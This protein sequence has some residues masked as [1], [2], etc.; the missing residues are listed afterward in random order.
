MTGD[1]DPTKSMIKDSQVFTDEY[2]P[3]YIRY[4]DKEIQIIRDKFSGTLQKR[5]PDHIVVAGAVGTGK[6][7]V[8]GWVLADVKDKCHKKGIALDYY[9]LNCTEANTTYKIFVDF[10]KGKG[11]VKGLRRDRGLARE[12]FK[13]EI[14]KSWH[15]VLV[16]DEFDRFMLKRRKDANAFLYMCSRTLRNLSLYLI[17]GDLTMLYLNRELDTS[18]ADTFRFTPILFQPYTMDDLR[19]ILIDRMHLGLDEAAWTP[20]IVGEIVRAS[21]DLGEGVRGALR[22]CRRAIERADEGGSSE[23]TQGHIRSVSDGIY[24]HD[25]ARSILDLSPPV[26]GILFWMLKVKQGQDVTEKPLD[27]IAQW[28]EAATKDEGF[29]AT[30]MS[31]H[32]Y[33][34]S[35]VMMG[36]LT[37]RQKGTKVMI[38]INPIF[39]PAI[40]YA[41]EEFRDRQMG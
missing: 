26:R 25:T 37:R 36:I 22:L 39:L 15:T 5:R 34:T 35:L 40:E 19:G 38:Q 29:S 32:R 41:Y 11:V 13:R 16:L 27:S 1:R 24:I 28:F 10:L 14:A 17:S 3:R 30:K 4:R 6:T 8:A 33:I 12:I 18:T 20:K 31:F 23:V 7:L 2:T 21:S 9:I